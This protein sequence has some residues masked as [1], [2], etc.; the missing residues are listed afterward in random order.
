M[1]MDPEAQI[2]STRKYRGTQL[3]EKGTKLKRIQRTEGKKDYTKIVQNLIRQK[4]EDIE[5]T[6]VATDAGG[7]TMDGSGTN[8]D[9]DEQGSKQVNP[10]PVTSVQPLDGAGETEAGGLGE[11]KV[12]VTF[13]SGKKKVMT[14]KEAV[15]LMSEDEGSQ[16]PDA[17][18]TMVND[19]VATQT[20]QDAGSQVAVDQG[21]GAT[22]DMMPSLDGT[23]NTP[24]PAS[25]DS[26]TLVANGNAAGA[27]T[28]PVEGGVS[29]DNETPG[30][31]YVKA[32]DG[33]VVGGP[34]DD[35]LQAQA[36][37]KPGETV[38]TMSAAQME[39]TGWGLAA[40]D[41]V[42]VHE[43]G[44]K[45][46]VDSGILAKAVKGGDIWLQGSKEAYNVKNFSVIQIA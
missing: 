28:T 41:F 13:K 23:A 42:M 15:K 9:T 31:Y 12:S 14:R 38:S 30:Q 1:N 20:P 27:V 37:C 8:H 18:K 3:S 35:E 44:S 43:K 26:P 2:A 32:A 40:G 5:D 10:D 22:P 39:N 16:N 11:S 36:Q 21:T 29:E 33:S 45:K 17:T 24:K 46:K 25:D 34:F 7:V 6:T 19:P 4:M